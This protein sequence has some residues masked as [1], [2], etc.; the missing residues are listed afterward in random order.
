MRCVVQLVLHDLEVRG[1]LFGLGV[2]VHARRVQLEHLTVEHLLAASDVANALEQ[3]PPVATAAELLE[4][5]V[6]HRE[7]LNEVLLQS[8]S[9]PDAELCGDLA[10]HA[11]ADG[12]DYIEVVIGQNAIDLTSALLPNCSEIPNSCS[13]GAS[14][15]DAR[16]S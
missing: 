10:P 9:R 16:E 14:R 11:V 3:L 5:G 1:R 13:R 12:Q 15:Q 2:V 7:A 6:I 8:C 4:L